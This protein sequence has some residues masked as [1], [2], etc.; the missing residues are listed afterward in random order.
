MKELEEYRGR[1]L[2]RLEQA[3]K[4]FRG[5]CLSVK[6]PYAPVEAGNWNVHQ[7]ATHTRDV[8]QL[9]YGLRARRT[10]SEDN[11]VFPNFDGE[12]YMA[13]HYDARESLSELLNG[14]VESVEA[15]VEWLRSLPPGG[16]SRVSSHS[17]LGR[18]LT[19]QTWVEKDLAHIEEHLE[20]VKKQKRNFPLSEPHGDSI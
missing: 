9:I 11:P 2:K 18:G 12:A 1:L 16:W 4:E 8:D 3:A 17:T 15:F 14:F 5:E 19:L 10:A 7:I 13:Q 20:A 6:D